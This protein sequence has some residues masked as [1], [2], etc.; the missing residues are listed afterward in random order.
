ML[1]SKVHSSLSVAP[2]LLSVVVPAIA[3]TLRRT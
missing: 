3:K 1:Q 2:V